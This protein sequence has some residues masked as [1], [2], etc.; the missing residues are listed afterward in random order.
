MGRIR[1]VVT[2]MLGNAVKFT[3]GPRVQIIV[4]KCSTGE[5]SISV[6]DT[7][8]GISEHQAA[9]IFD[10]F[11]QLNAPANRKFAGTG[12]GLPISR[13]LAELMGGKLTVVSKVGVG[14]TFTLTVGMTIAAPFEAKVPELEITLPNGSALTG[15]AGRIVRILAAEDNKTN[16]QVLSSMLKTE[17]VEIILAIDG[18]EA[19]EKF[20][21]EKPDIILMDLWMPSRQRSKSARWSAN[22]D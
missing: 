21:S 11:T 19:I 10:E 14:S 5:M 4:S 12:L 2:N 7:G 22:S 20:K 16:R 6:K 3:T 15:K 1:Q 9:L 13:R 8:P 18:Q 17:A